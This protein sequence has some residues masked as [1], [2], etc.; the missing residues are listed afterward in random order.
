MLKFSKR[1]K[2]TKL[3]GNVKI[4]LVI[5]LSAYVFNVRRMQIVV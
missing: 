3:L 2:K 1:K 4:L 5:C